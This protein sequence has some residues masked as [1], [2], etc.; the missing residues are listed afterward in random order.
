MAEQARTRP[1]PQELLEMP[2]ALLSRSDLRA[3]GLNRR[4]VDSV[5]R[6]APVVCLPG[7]RRPLIRVADYLATVEGS[8]YRDGDGRVRAA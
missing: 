7:Y 6:A 4:A 5:F 1:T 2:D 8:T 3:L